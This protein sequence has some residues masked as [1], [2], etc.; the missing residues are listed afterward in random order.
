MSL[1]DPL[2]VLAMDNDIDS[3]RQRAVQWRIK[4]R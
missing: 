2:V 3:G 4:A 1:R